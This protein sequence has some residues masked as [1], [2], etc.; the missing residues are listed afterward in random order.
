[1]NRFERQEILKGFGPSGQRKLKEAR[2]LVAGAGGLGCPA[3]LYLAAAGVGTIGIADGDLV[4]LSNLNRQILFG[5]QDI[6]AHK[7]ITAAGR[8]HEKYQDI[9]FN[10][11][12]EYIQ[13][14]NAIEIISNYHLVIDGT[15]NF[16]TRYMISDACVLLNK[17]YIFAS[18]FQNEGQFSVLNFKKYSQRNIHIRDLFPIAPDANQIPNCNELGVLGVLPGIMGTL[19]AAEAIKI[20]SGLGTPFANKLLYYNLADTRF[21]ELELTEHPSAELNRPKTIEEFEC[22]DYITSCA[23]VET[24]NWADALSAYKSENNAILIDVRDAKELP[25]SETLNC[26]QIP[27]DHIDQVNSRMLQADTIFLFCQTGVRSYKAATKL[28]SR[29]PDKHIYSIHGGIQ[30]SNSPIK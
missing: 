28:K 9:H 8:I 14:S 23:G 25:S 5:S 7:A 10:I 22:T 21:Y 4:S 30:D 18:I 19:Q 24:L 17:P 13:P 2:V 26:L 20:L 12:N 15:D 29:Y 3:L 27:L 6:G 16:P 1:M 11:H